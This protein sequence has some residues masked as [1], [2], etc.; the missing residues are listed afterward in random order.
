M[1]EPD[2]GGNVV[3]HRRKKAPIRESASTNALVSRRAPVRTGQ[4]FAA[5]M[6]DLMAD[7]VHGRVTPREAAAVCNAGRQLLRVVDM[8]HRY[9]TQPH[10]KDGAGA[11]PLVTS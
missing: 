1:E 5:L 2:Q 7:V 8:T 9:G 11:L 4:D 6:A 10:G 3:A